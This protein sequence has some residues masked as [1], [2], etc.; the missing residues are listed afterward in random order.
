MTREDLWAKL[1]EKSNDD[2]SQI[3][4]I[5]AAPNV[6]ETLV[7]AILSCAP[8]FDRPDWDDFVSWCDVE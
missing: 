4:Q 3:L 1:L 5:V 8:N 6:K 2:L 7:E